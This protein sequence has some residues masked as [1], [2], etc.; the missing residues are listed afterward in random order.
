MRRYGWKRWFWSGC[1]RHLRRYGVS[2]VLMAT[3]LHGVDGHA[4]TRLEVGRGG[5][6]GGHGAIA[7]RGESVRM[8]I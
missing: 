1:W 8:E 3:D 4:T 2:I 7:C 5:G 6:C